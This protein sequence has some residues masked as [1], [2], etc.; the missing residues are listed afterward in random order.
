EDLPQGSPFPMIAM[1]INDLINKGIK[2][3]AFTTS[4]GITKS[5]I[6]ETKNLTL[7]V[8]PQTLHPARYFYTKEIN[9][10]TTLMKRYRC[11]LIHSQWSYEFSIAA[12][13]TNI[14]TIVTLHDHALTILKLMILSN[15]NLTTKL[16]WIIRYLL[17][18]IVLK[19][20]QYLTVNSKYLYNLLPN[21][22][23]IKTRIINNFYSSKLE[24]N[25]IPIENKKNIL[26]S[27]SNGFN[28]RKNIDTALKALKIVRKISPELEYYLIG[29]SMGKNEVAHNYALKHNLQFGVRFLGRLSFNE[30]K[31]I[32]S[33]SIIFLHPSREESFGMSVLEAMVLG[34]TVIG[35]SNSGNIPKLLDNGNAGITCNINSPEE[36]ANS[37]LKLYKN[38]ELNNKLRMNAFNFVSSHY[39]EKKIIEKYLTY[40]NDIL[41]KK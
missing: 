5:Y 21:K 37:I 1:L 26:V 24:R 10:L 30:V 3:V 38:Q 32:V 19:R 39:S 25:L 40:Y 29:E 16:H 12:L 14:P 23:K 2:V 13:R 15:N 6:K 20:S 17:N 31:E 4:P 35:G 7:C 18:Q 27:I 41:K 22:Y 34:T 33:S 8:V 9:E 36:M 11:D 28:K